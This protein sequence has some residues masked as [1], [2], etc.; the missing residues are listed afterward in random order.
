MK[1]ITSERWQAASGVWR[2][3]GAGRERQSAQTAKAGADL[4]WEARGG[5]GCGV[6]GVLVDGREAADHEGDHVDVVLDLH[7]LSKPA[8]R[9]GRFLHTQNENAAPRET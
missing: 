8:T 5:R 9:Q 4:M 7:H 1:A 2:E 6:W 3:R